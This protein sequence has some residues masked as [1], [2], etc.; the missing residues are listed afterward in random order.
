MLK[1]RQHV[2][3]TGCT[4]QP[5]SSAFFVRIYPILNLLCRLLE[6]RS[7]SEKAKK[8]AELMAATS[9]LGHNSAPHRTKEIHRQ[10]HHRPPTH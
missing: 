10:H 2:Q 6:A 7:G 1:H 9:W 3:N 8:A 5:C 4:F